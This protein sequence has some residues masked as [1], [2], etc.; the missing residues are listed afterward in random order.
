MTNT[1]TKPSTQNINIL[2]GTL[3]DNLGTIFYKWSFPSENII[4]NSKHL[5][6][7]SQNIANYGFKTPVITLLNGYTRTHRD[8]KNWQNKLT[9][10]GYH[11]LL[12]DNRASGK[13]TANTEFSFDQFAKDIFNLW[14]LLNIKKTHLCGISM[15]GIIS[16]LLAGA[17]PDKVEKLIL[18]STL[19]NKDHF[20]P[21]KNNKK[22]PHH[23]LWH[24]ADLYFCNTK[25]A[26]K[27]AASFLLKEIKRH[28]NDTINDPSKLAQT[29]VQNKAFN[30]VSN[31][32][33]KFSNIRHK[34][35]IIH[36]LNDNIINYSA[37]LDLAKL[38]YN[39]KIIIYNNC[40]H[41]LLGENPLELFKDVL[42]FVES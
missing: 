39:S 30:S 25:S 14:Q 20:T 12:V 10:L 36:G 1:N 29:I 42:S 21:I 5:H 37:A 15:G 22:N 26:T 11:V 2:S 27:D 40:G 28:I 34:T 3:E 9:K 38:I 16:S 41:V 24:P 6:K 7:F 32:V 35:L 17:N 18:I 23:S 13:S 4:N 31:S 19:S 33:I 8:F